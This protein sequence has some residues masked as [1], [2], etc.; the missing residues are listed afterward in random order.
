MS[1]KLFDH[2]GGIVTVKLLGKRQEKVINMALSRGIYLWNVKKDRDSISFKIRSSGYEALKNLVDEN[3]YNMEVLD[4]KGLPFM[5]S[6]IQRRL[7]FLSGALIFVLALYI[8]SSFIWFIDVSGNEEIDKSKIL[9][10]ASKY[11]VYK[12]AAKW[13]FS[14]SE[15]EEAMLRDM[16]ELSYIKLDIRGVKADIQVVEKI[17]PRDEIS[18]PCHIVAQKDGIVKEILVLDGQANVKEGDVVARG[19]VLISGIVFPE[20][21]PYNF[22]D[23]EQECIPYVV[24]ARGVVKA[25]V[26]YEGYGECNL[27]EENRVFTDKEKRTVYIKSPWYDFRL[28]GDAKN[29]FKMSEQTESRKVLY[30]PVGEFEL[31]TVSDKEQKIE[32]TE[33][34]EKEAARIAREKALKTLQDKIAESQVISDTKIEVL[35]APSESILRIKVGVETIENIAAARPINNGE[36]QS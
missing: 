7:G 34:T 4:K 3:H 11:G 13:N 8:M 30:T 14:R 20:P 16:S 18:G 17:L 26:W 32:I 25:Q 2:M 9:I 12:G 31:L 19:D 36:N 35:S 5:K 33:Y 1:N 10:T 15:V 29:G 28:Y 22:E 24:R 21:S 6:T 23:V 27:H